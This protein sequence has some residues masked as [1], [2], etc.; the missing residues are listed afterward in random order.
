MLIVAKTHVSALQLAEAFDIDRGVA[1]DQDVGHAVIGQQR[2]QRAQSQ[3]LV[4]DLLDDQLAAGGAYRR[5]MFIEQALAN[6]A[7]LSG[8]IGLFKGI[9]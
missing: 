2:L 6:V 7:D 4:G 3:H 9:Q 1:I 5:G 8:G